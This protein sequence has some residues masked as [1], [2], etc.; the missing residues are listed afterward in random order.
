MDYTFVIVGVLVLIALAVAVGFARAADGSARGD[1]WRRIAAERRRNW[2]H[3]QWIREAADVANPCRD[4][5]FRR[6]R[7]G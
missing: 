7:E 4:C 6:P 2:E 3:R 1:A 5:P